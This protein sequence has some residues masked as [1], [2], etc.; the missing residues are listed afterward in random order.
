VRH[1]GVVGAILDDV[2][3]CW[4]RIGRVDG[5]RDGMAPR[6][7]ASP[8]RPAGPSRPLTARQAKA[9]H[10]ARFAPGRHR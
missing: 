4:P 2:A 8:M 10:R 9:H 6:A 1:Y 5:R 7:W 3:P